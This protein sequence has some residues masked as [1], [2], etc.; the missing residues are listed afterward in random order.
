MEGQTL[1]QRTS[2]RL[3]RDLL[4][5]LKRRAKESNTSLN[6]YVEG[7]LLDEVYSVPNEETLAAI[8]EA[9]SGKAMETLDLD[10]FNDFVASL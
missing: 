8:E 3:R 6:S 9:R 1:R 4:D 10:H 5:S 7:V 2:F